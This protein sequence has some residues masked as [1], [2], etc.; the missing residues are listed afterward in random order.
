[1]NNVSD[2]D[3]REEELEQAKSV[4]NKI[5][6]KNMFKKAYGHDFDVLIM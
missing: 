6:I 4:K 1:M 5:K 3:D 2:S